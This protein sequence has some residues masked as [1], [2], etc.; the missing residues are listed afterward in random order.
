[1]AHANLFSLW[2][3][4]WIQPLLVVGY[5][6]TL[7]AADLWKLPPEMECGVL[8][9][10]LMDNFERRRKEI[11]DWNKSLDDG[12]FKPSGMRRGWW[13]AKKSMGN[14]K[15]DGKRTVGLAMA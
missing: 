6:R 2:T 12:T 7:Q 13:K 5:Q 4:S 11:E 3:F 1:M 14:G 8:A 9:D 10:Q 15:G